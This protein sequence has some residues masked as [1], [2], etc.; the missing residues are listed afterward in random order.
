M[1]RTALVERYRLDPATRLYKHTGTFMKDEPGETPLV[2][3]P[4]PLV[5]DWSELEFD[6]AS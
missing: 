1:P 5:I 3:N 4:I 6:A 2:S